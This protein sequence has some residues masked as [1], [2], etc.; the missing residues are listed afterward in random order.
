M[1]GSL[2]HLDLLP[3]ESNSNPVVFPGTH[4][5]ALPHGEQVLPVMPHENEFVL[6]SLGPT[7]GEPQYGSMNQVSSVPEATSQILSQNLSGISQALNTS[8]AVPS[9]RGTGAP[10]IST[11]SEP[12]RLQAESSVHTRN[13]GIDQI[14][15]EALLE[16][17]VP[18]K[19]PTTGRI[20]I[21]LFGENFPA[22]PLYVLFGDNW[23]RA[24]S[25]ARYHY[26]F[27]LILKYVTEAVRCPYSA[28]LPPPISSSRCRE[29]DTIPNTLQE[30]TRG[31]ME[32]CHL[33]VRGESTRKVSPLR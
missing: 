2:H 31:R 22:V 29:R 8:S 27:E 4:T 10:D 25:Y 30:C 33:R 11:L 17:V 24:V 3:L 16:E 14:A 7:S 13:A 19:G 20:E 23:A 21:V 9:G 12:S 32:Y 6:R 28:M 26:P 1:L 15:G 18:K 5:S